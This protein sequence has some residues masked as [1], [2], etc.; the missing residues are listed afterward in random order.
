[1][2]RLLKLDPKNTEMLTQ[3]QQALAK[4][5]EATKEKLKT[6]KEAERQAQEQFKQGKMSE[7]QYKAL[8]REIAETEGKSSNPCRKQPTKLP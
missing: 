6:L 3:K 4:A 1:M 5:I 2:Q 7:E 8:Q